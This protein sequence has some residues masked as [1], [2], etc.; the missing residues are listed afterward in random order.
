MIQATACPSVPASTEFLPPQNSEFWHSLGI[1]PDALREKGD[2]SDLAAAAQ[3]EL[4]SVGRKNLLVLFEQ[5]RIER[6]ESEDT[7]S[8]ALK[9]VPPFPRIPEG[10]QWIQRLKPISSAQ[11]RA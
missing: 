7:G 6:P 8:L 4:R 11:H 5:E 3:K 9:P 1:F 10:F 2:L